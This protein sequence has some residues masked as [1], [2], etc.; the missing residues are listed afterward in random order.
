MDFG[1]T[2]YLPVAPP[3]FALLA[4]L[5]ALLFI[6]VQ[7]RLLKYAYMQ[8]GV[9]SATAVYLLL[10]SLIGGYVNI[11][12]ATLGRETMVSEDEVIYFGVP[13]VVPH[14]VH[15]PEVILAVNV[16]GAVVPTLLS[17]YLLSKNALWGRGLVATLC[18]TVI[19]HAFAEPVKG[20]GIALPI[21]VAP[22]AAT[23]VAAVVSWRHAAPLAY[24]GGCLGVLIGA[25]LLNLDKLEGVGTPVLSIGGA[26]TFDGVFLTGVL[27][28]L[29]ASLIGAVTRR[30][31][32][33]LQAS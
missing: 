20:V 14:F 16:G 32:E 23:L 27:A 33:P 22:L 25:D 6:L 28:V 26:G 19:S 24:A 2:H 30:R 29:L 1:H 8:L 17:V 12:I 18:V 21:F 13:Y 10:A 31:G 4:S 11:P 5:A 3:A 15:A 9:S 7:L